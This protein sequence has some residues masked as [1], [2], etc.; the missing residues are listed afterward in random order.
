MFSSPPLPSY[1]FTSFLQ[2]AMEYEA[3]FALFLEYHEAYFS[4]FIL[5]AYEKLLTHNCYRPL[6]CIRRWEKA[7]LPW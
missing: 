7:G 3:I 5:L 2:K 1:C 4:L 6:W